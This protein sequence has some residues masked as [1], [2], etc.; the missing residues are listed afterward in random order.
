MP[1]IPTR[2]VAQ[3]D[4]FFGT[5]VADP[6]RWLEDT[7][8]PEV[9]AWLAA[10]AAVTRD[11]LD[12]L[13]GRAAITAALHGVIGLPASGLPVHRGQHWFR[14]TNDGVQQQDVLRVAIEP[15]GAGR[16]LIDPNPLA[17]D[18]ST[19]LAA[20]VPSPDGTL[21]AYS[22]AEAGSDWRTW[23][24]RDVA[25]GVDRPDVVE[26][27]KFTWPGW[28]PDGSGFVYGHFSA[29]DGGEEYV[30]S[31]RGHQLSLHRLG[32]AQDAD[33]PVFALPDEPDV[34]FWPDITD[35]GR[36]L[37]VSGSRGTEHQVR[38][39]VRDLD[40]PGDGLRALIPQADASWRLV[41]SIS[42]E[43]VMI[44]DQG[45][46]LSRV[47][48]INAI[49][50]VQREL[51]G[52]RTDNLEDATLAGGR[53]VLHWLHDA[54]SRVTVHDI[55]GV[56]RGEIVL[57]G[58][59]SVTG[60]S[61]RPGESLLHL[62]FT[63]FTEPDSVL[64]YDVASGD[65]TTAFAP[66]RPG[67]VE[68]VTEQVWVTSADG[69]RLPVF[70]LHRADLT[71]GSGPHPAW[72]YGYGGFR[73]ATTPA[74]EPT[75]FSFAAAGG[76]VAVACLRGGGEYGAAWHDAGRLAAKQRVFDDAIA[77]AE[78]LI[79]TGW[80]S[81]RHLGASGRSNGGLLAGALLTQRPDLFAA[82][83]PEVGVLDMLRYPL[84]TIGWAWI[85]D[86]GDPRAD[87]AQFATLH[88][89]SPLHR[90]R[91]DAGY[92]PVLI[93]TSDHDDRVVPAHSI[94]F[95]AQLQAVSP[96]DAVTLLRVEASGGHRDGRSHDALIAERA[97]V[98]AFL[99]AHT[100]LLWPVT[101]AP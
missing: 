40:R 9:A 80:T 88:A 87:A 3:V 28:L 11:Y 100:G 42:D 2:T 16:V 54:S 10:Q 57:P 36:W 83:V 98:L 90:L 8:D 15:L 85:S 21:V 25:D 45:A 53:L 73:V 29:P 55:D 23:R 41:G 68:V 101:S 97:D 39:W 56:Q 26:W 70:L 52:E 50:G 66:S 17:E 7:D 92:P 12:A 47:V 63:S 22:Y 33:E 46:P 38:V 81:A 49:T 84:F 20:A 86:Y 89:Y 95:A 78:H 27:A 71:P 99:S 93:L 13:P 91:E 61:A 4:D 14:T 64:A 72:L 18:A 19:S 44:T 77:T 5:E 94:K 74:F 31:N 35:D 79:A 1:R 37:V 32:S 60:F 69:T 67:G 30:A 75:R 82:V 65:L 6:Y 24:V 59:G 62:G 76:V 58:L 48:A 51:V 96:E 43:L 34:T